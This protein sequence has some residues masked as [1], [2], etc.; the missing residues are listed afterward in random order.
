MQPLATPVLQQLQLAVV[1]EHALS[2]HSTA[3][4]QEPLAPFSQIES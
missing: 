3:E 1:L 2:T 4:R